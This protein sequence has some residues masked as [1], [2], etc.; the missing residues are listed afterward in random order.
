MHTAS[1][2]GLPAETH[3]GSETWAPFV[4]NPSLGNKKLKLDPVFTQHF[5]HCTGHAEQLL[6]YS[7][8]TI[9][10][11]RVNTIGLV[12]FFF[13]FSTHIKAKN[14]SYLWNSAQSRLLSV[15]SFIAQGWELW[16]AERCLHLREAI[17]K[18][19]GNKFFIAVYLSVLINKAVWTTSVING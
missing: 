19:N 5:C 2:A 13:Q 4:P 15:A 6:L 12:W 8:G 11:L 3:P 14:S 7:Y 17:P 18:Y 9:L 1:E 16:P 10:Y